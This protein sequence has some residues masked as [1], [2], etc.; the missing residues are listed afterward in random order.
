VRKVERW[1]LP[2]Q[3]LEVGV[4]PEKLRKYNLTIGQLFNVLNSRAANITPGFVDASERRFNLR[5]SGQ[6]QTLEQVA[7]TRIPGSGPSPL[8]IADV[9][10]VRFTN[11][12]PTYLGYFEH[13]PVVFLTLQQLQGTNIFELAEKVQQVIDQFRDTL[14]ADI[15]I[16][17]VFNQVDSVEKR[18]NGFFDNLLQGVVLVAILSLLF[19]G[20]REALI[21]TVTVPLS[22]VI[23]IGW[24]DLSGFGL[25][26]M[27]IVG[28]IIAL[29]LLVDDAI[30]VTESIHRV[31]KQITDTG[32]AAIEGA[33]RIGWASTSGTATT[34]LAFLPML[35]LPSSTGDFMRSMPVTVS[36][37]LVASL[38]LSLTLTPLMAARL[39]KQQHSKW[40]LQHATNWLAEHHYSNWI[41]WIIRHPLLLSTLGLLLL[42]GLLSLFPKIGVALFPKAEK[43]M[44][45]VNVRAPNNTAFDETNRII[46]G[47]AEQLAKDEQVKTLALNVGNSNPR[48]YYNHIP[49]RGEPNYGEILV[50]LEEYDH[51]AINQFIRHWR[52]QFATYPEAEVTIQEF[53]Q[54]PVTDPP[55]TFRIIGDDIPQL[56]QVARALEQQMRA[57]EGTV[58]VK[59]SII[60]PQVEVAT[61][62][63]YD[64]LALLGVDVADLDNGIKAH[65]TGLQAGTLKDQQGNSYPVVVQSTHQDIAQ[66]GNLYVPSSQ[67][68]LI[69][70][71]Q[72]ARPKLVEGHPEFY[73]YQK[74][75]TAKVTADVASG[76]SVN[77]LTSALENFM[78]DYPLPA[79]FSYQVGGEEESRQ[80]NFAGLS[81]VMLIS[82][83]G[84][85]AVLVLQFRSLLQPIIIFTSIPYAV[86]GATLGLYL[87]GY[88]FSIM[89]FVGLISLFG[90]VVNNA[91]I[92][93]DT[94][95]YNL[96]Q[97]QTKH[98]AVV[99]AS[100]T[101]F[102]PI[103]LTTL[104]TIGGLLPL[105]LFGGQLWA[106]LGWV[107]IYGLGV[108][109][110]SSLILVPIFIRVLSRGKQ[111]G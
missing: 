18:V 7:A 111:Q 67:G 34:I 6:Y 65:L 69:P 91:I 25:E 19:L 76:Y 61:E 16:S 45:L 70:I 60:E 54:G 107:I 102:T 90:I 27:S 56:Q 39:L 108:S 79:G 14:P 93:V 80:E 82:A 87:H 98:D 12:T 28:L 22:F 21:I 52:Q 36:L 105:T 84:I 37:V 20:F 88:A 32:K 100:S 94:T 3:I 85:F 81:H 74:I 103:I 57:L 47:I 31:K 95:N 89:A 40:T 48:I 33:S 66:L 77:Q 49:N 96:N 8:T 55:I 44:L 63:N 86:A 71:A 68:E 11:D 41:G 43:P 99:N 17:T 13:Q 35:M 101:R 75:R 64:R 104:T 110:L 10:S 5:V 51:R 106:P 78:A 97:G 30:V 53:Q 72:L 73:H 83:I 38:L 15:G 1:G 46:Q 58:N 24:L 29:G 62:I 109:T 42:V 92:L 59:N 26:Q 23:A 4:D 50:L 9:A 2:T